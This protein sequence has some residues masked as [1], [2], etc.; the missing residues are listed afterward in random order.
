LLFIQ[1]MV[2]FIEMNL[3]D[4]VL[5][6]TSI[7]HQRANDIRQQRVNWQ[8][9]LQSQM[10]T[11]EDYQFI[12]SF[13]SSNGEQRNQFL[14]QNRNQC[15]K[16]FLSLLSHISKDQTIQYVLCMLDDLILEDKSRVEIFKEYSK[17]KKESVWDPFLNL[18]NRNDGF[19][20]NMT[21][22]IISK[23]A[24]W[25]K[26]EPLDGSD[27]QIYFT[28]LRDQLKLTVN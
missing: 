24:C 10:I 8:S 20:Q 22:L 4:G 6:A 11:Q 12:S 1:K 25:S 2:T 7:L 5:A 14:Q 9:Y 26:T 27:L 18:L 15:S 17:K 28:W 23:I 21:A 16:T 3:T 13:E 19:I